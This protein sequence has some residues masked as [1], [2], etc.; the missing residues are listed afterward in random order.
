[1]STW[2]A[3]GQRALP[4]QAAAQAR[5]REIVKNAGG[6]EVVTQG[7]NGQFRDSDTVVPGNDP[8]P[9]VDTK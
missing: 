9:P 1:M 3:F 6:G 8:C 5:A 4:T 7:R 2:R